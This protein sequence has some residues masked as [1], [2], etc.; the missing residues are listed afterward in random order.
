MK[1]NL[2]SVLILALLVVNV[3]LTAVLMFSTMS[4]VKK[5]GQ[6]V[7]TIAAVL[8]IELEEDTEAVE[9]GELKMGDIDTHDIPD[10]LT[11]PLKKGEDGKDHYYLV[12]VSLMMDKTHED[13]ATYGPAIGDQDSYF[14]SIVIEVIG[15]HTLEEAKDNPEAMRAEI[16]SKIQTAYGSTFIYKVA[17]SNIMY[18]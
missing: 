18:Q 6:L 1:K 3:V 5:T 13:Y 12:N 8:N 17:F 14:K 4:S 2:I 9:S 7:T 16:L 11:I 15:E 10:T